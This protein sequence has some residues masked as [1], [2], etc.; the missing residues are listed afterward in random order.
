MGSQKRHK[1]ICIACCIKGLFQCFVTRSREDIY[2]V[3][4]WSTPEVRYCHYFR[5]RSVFHLI[6]KY[7]CGVM[8]YRTIFIR[9]PLGIHFLLLYSSFEWH[10]TQCNAKRLISTLTLAEFLWN[11]EGFCEICKMEGCIVW[12]FYWT[13]RETRNPKRP[14]KFLISSR[15][16]VKI[17]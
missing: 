1:L 5:R 10:A 13:H 17:N 9:E 3:S 14:K 16:D 4:I 7:S 6:T 11:G 15:E 8:T 12:T 2:T